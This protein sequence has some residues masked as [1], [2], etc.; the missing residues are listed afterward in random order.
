[1]ANNEL[2]NGLFQSLLAP[3]QQSGPN[4][5][6]IMA[7]M[8]SK[9]PMAA[10]MAV[11]SPSMAQVT[12][13]LL[14]QFGLT[15]GTP[16]EAMQQAV[17]ANPEMLQTAKGL[18]DLAAMAQQAGDRPTALRL[19]LM[20]QEKQV[21]EKEKIK[22]DARDAAELARINAQ[23]N[24]A[25][26]GTRIAEAAEGR[27]LDAQEWNQRYQQGTLDIQAGQ[28]A[29]TAANTELA[30][31]Q[32]QATI[33][34]RDFSN[35]QLK[36]TEMQAFDKLDSEIT[37]QLSVANKAMSVAER[38]AALKPTAGWAGRSWEAIKGAFGTEDEVTRLKDDFEGM[39]AQYA[40][41]NMPK[42][43]ASDKD[44][45]FAMQ[46]FPK[47]EYNA[48]Q[49]ESFMRGQAKMATLLAAQ[50]QMQLDYLNRNYE[51]NTLRGTTM[52]WR[53]EWNNI[54]KDP[55]AVNDFITE[56]FGESSLGGQPLTL[57][58]NTIDFNSLLDVNTSPTVRGR[59][60]GS[61]GS[62]R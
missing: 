15:T 39:Q 7:A 26:V 5:A 17:S 25:V 57:T 33:A 6:D 22:Q 62:F 49:V 28:I 13:G 50:K 34:Q 60:P 53:T 56:A 30:R 4:P 44:I 35:A 3:Q 58:P 55:S 27:A 41:L 42:G 48:E 23:T 47:K 43:P 46:G 16:Q 11:N 40:L 61:P 36:A 19:S 2:I 9:N 14:G 24:Q 8:N 12:K 59:R 37:A 10:A 20:S 38:Y 29:N 51:N 31:E 1:M 54:S 32:L 18:Q 21:E 52:G 45:A